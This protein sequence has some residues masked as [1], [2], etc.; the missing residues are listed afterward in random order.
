MSGYGS[1]VGRTTMNLNSNALRYNLNRTQLEMFK[2]QQQLQTN[3]KYAAPS[4]G[5]SATSAILQLTQ[6][7]QAREQWNLN[8]NEAKSSLDTIDSSLS[9]ITKT[10]LESIS[11]GSSQIGTGSTEDTR[12]DQAKVIDEQLKSILTLV[13]QQ[14]SGLSLFGGN[15]GASN[16]GKVFEDF[17]GGIRYVGGSDNLQTNFG[18]INKQDFTSNGLDAFGALSSRIESNVDLQIKATPETRLEDIEG[19]DQLGIRDGGIRVNV[20]GSEIYVNLSSAETMGDVV[21]RVND[22]INLS[23]PGAGSLAVTDEGFSLSATA[24]NNITISESGGGATASDLGIKLTATPGTTVNGP[25]VNPKLTP[26]TELSS[27]GSSVDFA[28][29][30]KVTQGGVTKTI[31]FSSAQTVEDMMNIVD[32]AELGIKLQINEAGTGFNLI[33]EVSGI[34]LTV[35]ENGGTTAHDLGISS[36][37]DQ[38]RLDSFREGLGVES[39]HDKT[40]FRVTTHDGTTFEVDVTG[41]NTVKDVIDRINDAATTAGL[42]VGTDFSVGYASDGTGITFSDNTTGTS[43]FQIEN[44]NESQAAEHLGIAKNAGATNSFTSDDNAKVVVQNIFT[45]LMDLSAALYKNDVSGITF[46]TDKLEDRNK[47]VILARAASSVDANR[48]AL[49]LE[50]SLELETSEK[51]MLSLIQEVDTTEAITQFQMLQVQLQASLQLGAQ[52]MQNSLM[53]FLR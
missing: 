28:S 27:F 3:Q 53:N 31:D 29:G 19:A 30:L 22:A 39:V 52:N 10:L 13:N 24:G 2:V 18:G 15:N 25:S 1:I 44:I 35:G 21:T 9:E 48:V 5:A 11:I 16:G 26:Q 4:D 41:A 14:Y 23:A 36:L 49:Q 43:D 42:T 38:T 32:Q 7:L 33:S 40:D 50:R 45:N 17:M 51:S 6:Q 37:G 20:N 34:R 46:A 47:E 12:K 8:L